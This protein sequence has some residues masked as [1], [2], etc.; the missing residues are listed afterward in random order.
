MIYEGDSLRLVTG[1]VGLLD[2]V[3]VSQRNSNDGSNLQQPVI[4][5]KYFLLVTESY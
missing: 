5:K 3:S 2:S 1:P 4:L